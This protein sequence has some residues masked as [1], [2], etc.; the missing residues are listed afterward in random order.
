M[1]TKS[2]IESVKNIK[3]GTFTRITY[4]SEVPM[5]SKAKKENPDMRIMKVSSRLF[6]LGVNYKNIQK[7]IDRNKEDILNGVVR[8]EYKNNFEN[9]FDNKIVHNTNTNKNYLNAYPFAKSGHHSYY[10][11]QGTSKK[12]TMYQRRMNNLDDSTKSLIIGSYFGKNYEEP[13]IQRLSV[14][15]IISIGK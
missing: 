8:K 5:S 1:N 3:N 2:V 14:E 7:V 9:I 4:M 11:I 15:N 6:R 12:G 13:S 10:L